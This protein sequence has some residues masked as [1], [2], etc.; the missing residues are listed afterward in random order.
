[1]IKCLTPTFLSQMVLNLGRNEGRVYWPSSPQM[2]IIH[3]TILGSYWA[4][5]KTQDSRVRNISSDY[6]MRK[7]IKRSEATVKYN[8]FLQTTRE[9]HPILPTHK[10]YKIPQQ[11]TGYEI[12]NC[13]SD[14]KECETILPR[15]EFKAFLI[16]LP[17][18]HSLKR[19]LFICML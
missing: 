9:T 19:S 3:T 13:K 15:L 2:L 4:F 8:F 18:H 10:S 11:K 5:I 1:M 14:M 7:K 16:I 17:K 12:W 6:Q